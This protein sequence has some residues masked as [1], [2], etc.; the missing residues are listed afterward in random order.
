MKYCLKTAIPKR[1]FRWRHRRSLYTVIADRQGNPQPESYCRDQVLR[2]IRC[3][4]ETPKASFDDYPDD[5]KFDLYFERNRVKRLNW[6]SHQPEASRSGEAMLRD[7]H[8]LA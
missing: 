4:P 1:K 6:S 5:D 7:A 8:L 3:L 2:L